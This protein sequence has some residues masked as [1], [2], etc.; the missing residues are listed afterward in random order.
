MYEFEPLLNCTADQSENYELDAIS[1]RQISQGRLESF[2]RKEERNFECQ[3]R[4]MKDFMIECPLGS[5]GVPVKA[6]RIALSSSRHVR[7]FNAGINIFT[8]ILA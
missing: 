4:V 3:L 1:D 5:Y 8:F 7:S 6:S 2:R